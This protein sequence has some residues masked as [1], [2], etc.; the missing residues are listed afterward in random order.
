MKDIAKSA[1]NTVDRT[2][3]VADP[4]LF[5]SAFAAGEDPPVTGR[6][7]A[8]YE[9]VWVAFLVFCLVCWIVVW[10]KMPEDQVVA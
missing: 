8:W 3:V 5:A 9:P 4:M 10:I 1:A 7:A 2:P 6:C